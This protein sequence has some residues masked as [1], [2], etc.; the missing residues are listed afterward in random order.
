MNTEYLVFPGFKLKTLVGP[1]PPSFVTLDWISPRLGVPSCK[2]EA[3]I[4]FYLSLDSLE[5]RA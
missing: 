2:V 3:V 4:K 1:P 5:S